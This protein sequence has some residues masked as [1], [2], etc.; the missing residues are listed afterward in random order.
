M[1]ELKDALNLMSHTPWNW[2]PITLPKDNREVCEAERERRTK[3][4]WIGADICT[5]SHDSFWKG[6]DQVDPSA[7]DVFIEE[8]LKGH[9]N[10]Y[11]VPRLPLDP[12]LDWLR[13]NPEEIC[14]YWGGPDDPEEIR[15]MVGTPLHDRDGCDDQ[16]KPYPKQLIA[17]QSFSSKKWL[18]DGAKALR[19][20]IEHLENGPWADQ[21]LGYFVCF[22]NAGETMWWGDWRDQGDPRRGDFGISHRKHFFDWAVEKYGSLEALRMAWNMPELTRENIPVPTPPERWSKNGKDLRG[23]LLVDDQRQ[24]DC[25]EFHSKACFDALETFGKVI[26]DIRNKPVGCFYGFFIDETAGYAGHLA[27]DR[28]L[29][30]PYLDFYSLSKGYHYCLAGDPG[31]SQ[32]PGQSFARKK[33][34]IEENDMR[35]H[36]ALK[37][38]RSRANLN[39]S[40]TF[41]CFWRELYRALTFKQGFYWMNIRGL[42]DDWFGDADMVSMLKAQADFYRKW[43]TV[44][45]KD[46]AEI[47]FVEDE[48]SNEHMTYLSG[49]LRGLRLRL[50]R[51]LR[52]CGAPVDHFR[53][54]DMLDMDLSRYKFIVF[55]HAFVM[56]KEKWHKIEARIRP[57]AHILWN[58]AAALLEPSFS[59]ENQKA[60]TGFQVAECPG[61]MQPPELY[62]HVYWHY[63][64]ICPQDYPL[65]EIV[66]EVGQEVLQTSPDKKILTAR[67][68]REQGASIYSAELTLREPIL[69]RLLTDAGVRFFA[70]DN[71]SVLADEKLIGFFPRYNVSFTYTFDGTWRNVLTG[72]QVSGETQL[73]IREKGLKLFEKIIINN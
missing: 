18:Q 53:V 73:D 13:A 64:D 39:F 8:V 42:E 19:R 37:C 62:R 41:T 57:D 14:V 63:V 61:R 69:R 34:W 51:E 59:P 5:I 72:E 58:Y 28:A 25:N 36:H 54:E 68:P 22:G 30:T 12:P 32:A 50:E 31:S 20:L 1:L 11:V 55:C 43:V 70:P 17:N 26:K 71:C 52:L 9:P 48:Q 47:L 4:D 3:M 44:H 27:I 24:A 21:I 40:D 29:T 10:R 6:I 35:S 23:V 56:P 7:V 66:P 60:V 65:L 46:V 16:K 45:R 2:Y 49:Q 15:A 67:I 38:D 33:L